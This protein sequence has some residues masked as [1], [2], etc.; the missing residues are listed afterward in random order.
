MAWS[1][2]TEI[3][4]SN[5]VVIRITGAVDSTDTSY[6]IPWSALSPLLSDADVVGRK[7]T[8]DDV[9]I[10]NIE[11]SCGGWTFATGKGSA[12]D[13]NLS[14]FWLTTSGID[15]D[16]EVFIGNVKK[17]A[18]LA[19]NMRHNTKLRSGKVAGRRVPFLQRRIK[20]SLQKPMTS[21]LGNKS[22]NVFRVKLSTTPQASS[23]KGA[24]FLVTFRNNS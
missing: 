12:A 22:D 11:G 20:G 10:D 9:I 5:K 21:T 19:N 24:T 13:N 1:H 2:T 4:T 16:E 15:A 14:F 7:A 3:S 8:R 17:K 6:D 23:F 18:T